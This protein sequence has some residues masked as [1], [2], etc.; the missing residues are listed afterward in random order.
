MLLLDGNSVAQMLGGSRRWTNIIT[1]F[2]FLHPHLLSQSDEFLQLMSPLSNAY[3]Q[4]LAHSCEKPFRQERALV[5]FDYCVDLRNPVTRKRKWI[6][7]PAPYVRL[8]LW[9]NISIQRLGLLRAG[10]NQLQMQPEAF[11]ISAPWSFSSIHVFAGQT[12]FKARWSCHEK[13]LSGLLALA[14]VWWSGSRPH[15][16]LIMV[17][18]ADGSH[19][20]TKLFQRRDRSSPVHFTHTRGCLAGC[21]LWMC[22]LTKWHESCMCSLSQRCKAPEVWS[23]PLSQSRPANIFAS[24]QTR[25][26]FHSNT[27]VSDRID[28]PDEVKNVHRCI[29]NARL[30]RSSELPLG[31]WL[32]FSHR[33]E[34]VV[35]T[36]GP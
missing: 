27:S 10:L 30:A 12:S 4:A 31:V 35:V 20:V 11:H 13:L 23:I 25:L 22:D 32:W 9:S 3:S 28:S 26:L 33:K 17:S 5:P 14:K 15:G 6:P 7:M 34:N 8:C 24:L 16:V 2:L 36:N 19:Q 21:H 18:L 29:W 1:F